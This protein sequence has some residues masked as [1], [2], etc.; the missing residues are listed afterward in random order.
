M[1]TPLGIGGITVVGTDI[2]VSVVGSGNSLVGSGG[3]AGGVGTG[4][5]GEE[6]EGLIN[7][8]SVSGSIERV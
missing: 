6:S 5:L 1:D 4:T 3:S 7:E 2:P 8:V